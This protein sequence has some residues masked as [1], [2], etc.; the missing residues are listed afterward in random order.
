VRFLQVIVV[1]SPAGH[2]RPNAFGLYDMF[3]NAW[4]W[5]ADCWRE[6]YNGAS[7]DGSAWT[8]GC[9]DS[10]H[11]LRGGSWYVNPAY[12]RAAARAGS[13]S[14]IYS[15]GFRVARTLSP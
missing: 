1:T 13:S 9:A 12:V 10:R 4:Q 11:V 5:V 3:G 8:T 7:A 14:E 2:Y 15:Y 6:D